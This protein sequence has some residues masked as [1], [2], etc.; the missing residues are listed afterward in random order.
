MIVIIHKATDGEVLYVEGPFGSSIEAQ[1]W[2][3]AN[4][5]YTDGIEI[6]HMLKPLARVSY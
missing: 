3:D 5:N 6:K 4:W 2:I 1:D